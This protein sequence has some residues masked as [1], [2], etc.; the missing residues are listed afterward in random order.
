MRPGTGSG[1]CGVRARL[2]F[3]QGEGDER[4]AGGEVRQPAGFLLVG[5]GE[6]DRQRAKL[7]HGEDQAARGADP[8]DLLDREAD[9]QELTTD[10]AELRRERQAQDV[11]GGQELLDVPGKFGRPVDLGGPWRDPLVGEDPH[12]VAEELLLLRQPVGGGAGGHRAGS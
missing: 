2:G 3:G 12:G 1:R 6:Q 8:A 11:L 10:A 7:L 4:P 9:R 5:T